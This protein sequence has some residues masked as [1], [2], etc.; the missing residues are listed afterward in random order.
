MR[1]VQRTTVNEP[2]TGLEN[3]GLIRFSK[4]LFSILVSCIVIY[5]MYI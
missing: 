1:K 3:L 2:I 4:F 5:L